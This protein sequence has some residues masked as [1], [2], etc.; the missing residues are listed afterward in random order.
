M[1]IY[2]IR[3]FSLNLFSLSALL[4]AA[5][6]LLLA[7]LVFFFRNSKLHIAWLF[8]NL[9]VGS[10]A[11]FVFMASITNDPSSAYLLW[12]IAHT[13]GIYVSITFFHSV[14]LYTK[15]SLRTII[16][17]SYLYGL[18][19]DYL[20][21]I[22]DGHIIYDPI[23]TKF[24]FN[25]IH[26]LQFNTPDF[27]LALSPWFLLCFGGLYLLY[28]HYKYKEG[29]A[30]LDAKVWMI[31]MIIGYTGGASS[32][33]PMMK[34]NIYPLTMFFL[35]TYGLILTYVIFKN[36]FLGIRFF[37]EKSI[38]YSILI[39]LISLGYLLLVIGLEKVFYNFFQYQSL[40]V[41]ILTAFIIG[42]LILPLR[43]KIQYLL[44][45]ALFKGSQLE[46]SKE[47]AL[48]RNEVAKAE[49]HKAIASLASNIAHEI[50]NPLTALKTFT[51]FLPSK[52]DEPEF[53]ER[54]QHVTRQELARIENLTKELL[55]FAKPAPPS[56]QKANIHGLI[57]E[58]LDLLS[59]KI[60]QKN[61]KVNKDYRAAEAVLEI[62]A[63]QI[64]QILLNIIMNAVEAMGDMGVLTITTQ[65]KKSFSTKTF[66]LTI[67]DS[68][69]GIAAE[70][71]PHI[72]EPFFTKKEN[73][74][75]LGLA[76]TKDIIEKH[77]GKI[78]VESELNKG[79]QF[80]I[81]LP[82]AHPQ[83]EK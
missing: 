74:T 36:Q 54:F 15:T 4:T 18:I 24:L 14:C 20:N 53:L 38:I 29:P 44:D 34:L 35:P 41:S 5:T 69:V 78:M 55:D 60:N 70:D 79:T 42:A 1:N 26:Y 43:N 57:D 45:R 75:G 58:I 33:L 31:C 83:E 49:R 50:K 3:I 67:A 25:S 22:L 17:L 51:E 77:K 8:F 27:L 7:L 80:T 10:W 62:D 30:S 47:N 82:Y 76:I 81:K 40:S 39:A 68:G 61:I 66:E 32:F 65:T 73:G 48:L 2:D 71:L 63:N 46:I 9:S 16:I 59:N 12:R 23:H 13:F 37:L 28:K 21:Y 72:F 64:K 11:F 19:F 52:K 6:S 56:F